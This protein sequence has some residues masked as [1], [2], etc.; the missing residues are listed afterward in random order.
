MTTGMKVTRHNQGK[1]WYDSGEMV[2]HPVFER[3]DTM[4]QE[5]AAAVCGE[6]EL[7]YTYQ[8]E[9]DVQKMVLEACGIPV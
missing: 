1:E 5:F 7:P 4:M 3:Y 6:M 2:E 8:S 9:I